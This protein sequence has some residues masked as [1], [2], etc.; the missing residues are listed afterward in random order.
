[1][2][3]KRRHRESLCAASSTPGAEAAG[4][5]VDWSSPSQTPRRSLSLLSHPPLQLVEP[6]QVPLAPIG[7]LSLGFSPRFDGYEA[8]YSGRL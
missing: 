3:E 4:G 5:R 6:F 2:G 8:D 1:M 7:C